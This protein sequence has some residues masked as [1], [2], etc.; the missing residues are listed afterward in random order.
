MFHGWTGGFFDEF[1]DAKKK[2]AMKASGC[3]WRPLKGHFIPLESAIAQMLLRINVDEFDCNVG[4]VFRECKNSAG[5]IENV[6]VY[7]SYNSSKYAIELQR[8]INSSFLDDV[9]YRR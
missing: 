3:R 7:N 4:P 9:I 1:L 2:K 5:E 8:K 6:R